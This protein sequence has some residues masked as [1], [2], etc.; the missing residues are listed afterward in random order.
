MNSTQPA[1][2][3]LEYINE[4][5]QLGF[6]RESPRDY[7]IMGLGMPGEEMSFLINSCV[8]NYIIWL[9]GLAI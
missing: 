2:W 4:P 8:I 5:G 9:S 6:R 1:E 3:G 7:N